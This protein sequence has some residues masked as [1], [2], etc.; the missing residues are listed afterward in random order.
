[1]PKT[2]SKLTV[3]KLEEILLE[4]YGAHLQSV[5]VHDFLLYADFLPGS[6]ELLDLPLDVLIKRMDETAALDREE[7]GSDPRDTTVGINGKDF[8]ISSIL[9][10]TVANCFLDLE[11][12]CVDDNGQDLRLPSVRVYL[13]SLPNQNEKQKQKQQEQQKQKQK[14]RLNEKKKHDSKNSNKNNRKVGSAVAMA[15]K[16]MLNWLKKK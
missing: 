14:Q 8:E 9:S 15:G 12:V 3:S 1:M 4:R 5:S 2:L 6:E 10:S 11:V 16:K 7:L 13:K